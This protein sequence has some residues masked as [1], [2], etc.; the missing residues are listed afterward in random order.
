MPSVGRLSGSLCAAVAGT[1]GLVG[2]AVAGDCAV[3]AKQ[4]ERDYDIPSG[5]VQAIA[6]VESGH[7][8]WAVA[9]GSK[10]MVKNDKD[11]AAR[12]IRSR[13]AKGIY[14]GCMQ[15]SVKHHEWAFDDK[16]DML[17]PAQNVDYGAQLLVELQEATGNWSKAVQRYQ[18]GSPA[19]QQRY[20]CKIAMKLRG[21]D[22]KSPAL[23]QLPR[24]G[25]KASAKP[26]AAT[27]APPIED[28]PLPAF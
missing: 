16:L 8:P 5:L 22:P 11:D 23:A 14:V 10:T 26:A 20:A 19:Q 12:V 18:G 17:D 21:I 7:N 2:V 13:P 25:E 6:Q 28:V 1:I 24:C 15:L 9:V 4:A 27:A 3:L